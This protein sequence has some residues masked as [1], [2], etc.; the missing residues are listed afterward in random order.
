M[1]QDS[2]NWCEK[3]FLDAFIALKGGRT[4]IV[5]KMHKNTNGDGY[6][7]NKWIARLCN[8]KRGSKGT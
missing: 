8:R 2:V 5:S 3:G 4:D 7:E 6:E 1:F